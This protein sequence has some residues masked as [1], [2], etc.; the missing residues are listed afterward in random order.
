MIDMMIRQL[1]CQAGIKKR[2]WIMLDKDLFTGL[3]FYN[4]VYFS[5]FGCRQEKVAPS[6]LLICWT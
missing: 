4:F 2:V 5:P 3:R 1:V 6:L